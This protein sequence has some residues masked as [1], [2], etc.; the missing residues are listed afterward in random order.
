MKE[1]P[2]RVAVNAGEVKEE[3]HGTDLLCLK[4]GLFFTRDAGSRQPCEIIRSVG[5]LCQAFVERVDL[6]GPGARLGI[7]KGG[8]CHFHRGDGSQLAEYRE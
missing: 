7:D 6:G 4:A 2:G 8:L 3:F 5:D 1:Q